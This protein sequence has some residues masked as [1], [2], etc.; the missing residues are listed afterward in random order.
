[1]SEI[2][3]LRNTDAVIMAG[4]LRSGM[5]DSG[6]IYHSADGGFST[7][8][9][10]IVDRGLTILSPDQTRAI[11]DQITITAFLSQILSRPERKAWFSVGDEIFTV[12]YV[13]EDDGSRVVCVVKVGS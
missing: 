13:Q 9:D 1:M 3:F 10:V 11:S 8:C 12:D 6:A 5:G 4:L 2:D 7:N